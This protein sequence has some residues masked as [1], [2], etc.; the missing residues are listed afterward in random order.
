MT[1]ALDRL[2]TNEELVT[3]CRQ[4]EIYCRVIA[5]QCRRLGGHASQ[6]ACEA[7]EWKDRRLAFERVP[8]VPERDLD[9]AH[10]YHRR[11]N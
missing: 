9:Q 11:N 8:F 2:P 5:G 1:E 6:W 3:Y 4:Q 7:T 10:A